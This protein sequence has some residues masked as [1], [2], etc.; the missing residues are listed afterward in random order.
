MNVYGFF[1][2]NVINPF[3]CYRQIIYDSDWNPQPDMQA[4]DRAHRIGQKKLV[5]V[6]RLITEHTVDERIAQRASIKLRLN[7]MIIQSGRMVEK[8]AK[9]TSKKTAL[10]AIRFGAEKILSSDFAEMVDVDIDQ[11]LMHGEAK[12]AK[13][14][15]MYDKLDETELRRATTLEEVSKDSIFKFEGINYRQLREEQDKQ[16]KNQ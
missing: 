12:T 14:N 10:D 13:E 3:V 7:N 1:S 5:R 2:P 9:E 15:A 4:I 11:I 6:F 16:Q 8:D